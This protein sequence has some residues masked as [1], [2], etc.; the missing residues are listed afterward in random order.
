MSGEVRSSGARPKLWSPGRS[1]TPLPIQH[2]PLDAIS[3]HPL[4]GPPSLRAIFLATTSPTAQAPLPRATIWS[5]NHPFRQWTPSGLSFLMTR[6]YLKGGHTTR[7]RLRCSFSSPSESRSV[8]PGNRP[9]RPPGYSLRLG[10][11]PPRSDAPGQTADEA[12]QR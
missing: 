11:R 10:S 1:P 6:R 12:A 2:A 7:G 5:P 3:R 8:A 9:L 4:P